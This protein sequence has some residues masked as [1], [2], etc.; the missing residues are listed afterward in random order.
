MELYRL[1]LSIVFG[2]LPSLIWL[3]YYLAKDLHPEPKKM[4]LK[5]FFWGALAT[6][7]ALFFQI[8]FSEGLIYFQ[9]LYSYSPVIAAYAPAAN[10]IIKWFFIIALTEELCKYLVVRLLVLKSAQIDEPLDIM[11]YMVVAALGFAALEN[12]LYL[13]SPIEGLSFATVLKTTLLISFLRFIGAT[14]LHTLCAALIGYFM[15]LSSIRSKHRFRLTALGIFLAVV[16]HGL[17]NFS[18]IQLPLPF[19]IAVPVLIIFGLAL[20]MVYDFDGIKKIKSIV[21]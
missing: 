2:A 20:F 15:A 7:P 9:Y 18:I 1:V 19:S 13:F 11:L 6:I 14:F 10:K 3:W 17:Y 5:V 12:A 16:L 4:I 8:L 21:I